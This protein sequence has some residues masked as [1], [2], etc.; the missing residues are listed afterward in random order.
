MNWGF[1]QKQFSSQSIDFKGKIIFPI[2]VA[3]QKLAASRTAIVIAS[4]APLAG[5]ATNDAKNRL[6]PVAFGNGR[7]LHRI[8]G[9]ISADDYAR[10][11]SSRLASLPQKP[12][13]QH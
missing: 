9:S 3:D 4:E 12:R 7:R 6:M 13:V 8:G 2:N 10:C 1:S 11:G 5:P